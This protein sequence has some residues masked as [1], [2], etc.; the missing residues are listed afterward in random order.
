MLVTLA[1][2]APEEAGKDGHRVLRK[3]R[4]PDG[5]SPGASTSERPCCLACLSL[6]LMSQDHQHKQQPKI[7]RHVG[8]EYRRDGSGPQWD[9]ECGP[10]HC[11]LVVRPKM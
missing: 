11:S 1:K 3:W 8:R 9:V 2:S 4:R 7:D 6:S 10:S 5:W